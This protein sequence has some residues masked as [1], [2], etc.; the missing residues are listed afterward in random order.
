MHIIGGKYK[1][2]TLI[3]PDSEEVRPTSGKLR[4]TIF[5][6]C[7]GSILDAEFLD[8][9]AG[10]GAVGLEALSRGAKHAT[11]VEKSRHAAKVIKANIDALKEHTHT[12]LI[13]EDAFQALRGFADEGRKFDIIFADPPYRMGFG[14][15]VLEAVDC[16][17]ILKPGGELFIEDEESPPNL[18][19]SLN[20]LELKSSRK[21]GR[22]LLQQFIAK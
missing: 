10:S 16:L 11:F 20:H 8:L 12:T 3:S 9:F 22:T 4:E 14:I 6:I 7:Q 5:N 1:K 17:A 13:A 15:K 18:E 21:V 19:F 2:K